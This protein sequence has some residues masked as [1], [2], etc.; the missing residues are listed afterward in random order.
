MPVRDIGKV[1]ARAL[2]DRCRT[3]CSKSWKSWRDNNACQSIAD[4]SGKSGEP[5]WYRTI[6][7]LIK[8]QMLYP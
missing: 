6:D 8:S 5:G 2:I 7:P 3:A 1:L 4:G